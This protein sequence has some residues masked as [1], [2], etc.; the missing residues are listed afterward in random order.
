MKTVY[1]YDTLGI[2]AGQVKFTINVETSYGVENA[3][4]EELETSI[5][6]AARILEK[7]IGREAVKANPES[8][9]A[10]RDN[11]DG[12]LSCFD[13]PV[14]SK[15]LPN[16]YCS[17]YCCAHLPWFAVITKV[18]EIKIGWRKR[19]LEIDWSKSDNKQTASELFPSEDVTKGW[20]M[21]HAWGYDKAREY[22]KKIV[23]P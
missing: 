4:S 7:A 22:I 23:G 8:A 2:K 3:I 17:D 9:I 15:E 20:Q 14:F 13:G 11:R 16:G 5:C 12:I 1:S 21:I 19:V 10:A 18:G 6:E